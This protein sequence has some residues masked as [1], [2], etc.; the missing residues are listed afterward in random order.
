MAVKLI[1]VIAK[2]EGSKITTI[3]EREIGIREDEDFNWKSLCE[4]YIK[5]MVQDGIIP[6]PQQR[7][8]GE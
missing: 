4:L 3:S 7:V 2:R 1:E 5:K 6:D 8:S